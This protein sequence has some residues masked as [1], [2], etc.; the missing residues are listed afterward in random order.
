MNLDRLTS[1]CKQ[2]TE[3]N[4]PVHAMGHGRAPATVGVS[5]LGKSCASGRARQGR[6]LGAGAHYSMLELQ[7]QLFLSC[8]NT[9]FE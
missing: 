5:V 2:L 1:D 3:N 9:L 4:R 6:A 7:S 8:A